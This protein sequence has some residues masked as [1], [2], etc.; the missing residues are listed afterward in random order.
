MANDGNRARD[1]QE[2]PVPTAD[3]VPSGPSERW[4]AD[5]REPDGD[6]RV[7]RLPAQEHRAEG[8]NGACRQ[9]RSAEPRRP[10]TLASNIRCGEVRAEAD[11]ERGDPSA[12]EGLGQGAGEG[13]A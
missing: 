9:E 13:R 4:N 2:D 11:E 7:D 5:Q 1:G 6:I 8:E 10:G 12:D 3:Q